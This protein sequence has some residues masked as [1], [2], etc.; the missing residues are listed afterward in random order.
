[1]NFENTVLRDIPRL[2]YFKTIIRITANCIL[3]NIV[4]NLNSLK[5]QF[6]F[7]SAFKLYSFFL[8]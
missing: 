2:E 8:D 6:R 5:D 1:M 7:T 3:S 4:K